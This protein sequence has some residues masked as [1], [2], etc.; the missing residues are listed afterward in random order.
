[1]KAVLKAKKFIFSSVYNDPL[2]YTS[3]LKWKERSF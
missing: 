2:T 3:I 1:M